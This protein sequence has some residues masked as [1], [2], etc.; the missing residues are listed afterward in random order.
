[1]CTRVG[2]QPDYCVLG[3]TALLVRHN[4]VVSGLYMVH[5]VALGRGVHVQGYVRTSQLIGVARDNCT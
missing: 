3:G 4:V 2:C 5:I 1:M